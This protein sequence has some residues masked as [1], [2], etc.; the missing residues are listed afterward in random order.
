MKEVDAMLKSIHRRFKKLEQ[1]I[2][3]RNRQISECVQTLCQLCPEHGNENNCNGCTKTSSVYLDASDA[4]IENCLIDGFLGSD[5][6]SQPTKNSCGIYIANGV[7][8]NCTVMNCTSPY[9]EAAGVAGILISS[10]S[11]RAVNCVSV[12]NVDS[13]GTVRAFLASQVSRAVNCAFDAIEGE[14]A[15]PDGMVNPV[16]G[17]AAS[18]FK[19]YANGDYTPAGPLV[20]KGANYEGMAS[21]DLAG[22]PRKVGSKIDIGCYEARSSSLALIIR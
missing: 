1:M 13:N 17:T 11:G 6:P 10:D 22:N 14:A 4:R 3:L 20:N 18:F 7:A 9:T 16:V 19:D 12:A 8:A 21:V 15:I 2:E 5:V